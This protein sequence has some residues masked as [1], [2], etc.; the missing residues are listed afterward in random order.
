MEH[1][2]PP[3]FPGTRDG[4]K[5]VFTALFQAIPDFR[6]DIDDIVAEGDVVAIRTTGSGTMTGPFLGAKPA[7]QHITW[8]EIHFARVRDG[9]IVE[10]WDVSDRQQAISRSS[11]DTSEREEHAMTVFNVYLNF[12][13]DT[14]EAFRFYQSVLGGELTQIVRFKDM[15]MEGMEI[16][17]GDEGK[18]MHMGLPIGEGQMLMGTDALE[19]MG[20][21]LVIGNNLSISV[22]PDS[23]EEADRIFNGLSAGG[24]VEMPM[25][26]QPWGDYY[27]SFQ[28]RY[29]VHWMVNYHSEVA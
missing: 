18:V 20:Q 19:S 5:Q 23:K 10:H 21:H 13:G 27:G 7:E 8:P 15:P 2:A 1:S 12:A 28:D 22:H 24:E 11:K 29:G 25:A 9:R 16:P 4:V 26:N 14:E 6:Y 17:A 3:Q